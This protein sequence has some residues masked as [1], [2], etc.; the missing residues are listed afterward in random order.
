MRRMQLVQYLHHQQRERTQCHSLRFN[1]QHRS[2]QL[3]TVDNRYWRGVL[4]HQRRQR[5]ADLL[6]V[7]LRKLD[8]GPNLQPRSGNGGLQSDCARRT[9]VSVC[10]GDHRVLREDCDQSSD[11]LHRR[12]FDLLGIRVRIQPDVIPLLIVC[13]DPTPRLSVPIR[14]H[15]VEEQEPGPVLSCGP[16][17]GVR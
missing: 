14:T 7:N 12:C 10:L 6:D 1:E 11:Q 4:G 13:T 17:Q 2:G 15:Q 3:D 9:S 8:S 16:V 5:H